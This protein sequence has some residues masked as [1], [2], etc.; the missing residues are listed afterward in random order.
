MSASKPF[1]TMGKSHAQ[2]PVQSF[3]QA[4]LAGEEALAQLVTGGLGKCK[5]VADFFCGLGPFTLRL[6]E[7]MAVHGFDSDRAAVA[8]LA[9]AVRHTQGLRPVTAQVRD[10]FRAPLVVAELNAFDGIVLDPPRA[11]AEAQV[12][13]IAK[14]QVKLLVYVACD[15][16]TFARD[17]AILAEGGYKLEKV[18]PVDQFKWTAHLEMVGWFKK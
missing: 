17:A 10:L 1:V 15:V 8:M 6:A 12:R 7:S 5:T 14:S 18:F 13:L 3:L 11:G 2:L 4:T 16:Q 9:Q